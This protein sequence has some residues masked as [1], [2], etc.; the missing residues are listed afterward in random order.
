M[1]LISKFPTLKRIHINTPS[2]FPCTL[3][4]WNALLSDI[5]HASSLDCSKKSLILTLVLLNKLYSY[6]VMLGWRLCPLG[7]SR[8]FCRL[9]RFRYC[10]CQIETS[11]GLRLPSQQVTIYAQSSC[12]TAVDLFQPNSSSIILVAA[13][14]HYSVQA[15]FGLAQNR[16]DIAA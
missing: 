13:Q 7:S 11:L 5:V 14:Y 4:D 12:L 8:I 9:N 15:Q 6:F 10:S 1:I 3:K 2:I 16:Y